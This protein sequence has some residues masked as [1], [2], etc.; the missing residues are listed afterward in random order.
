MPPAYFLNAPTAKVGKNA[1][2][3]LR[4]RDNVYEDDNAYHTFTQDFLFRAVRR[5]VF[6]PAPLPLMRITNNAVGSAVDKMSG[7]GAERKSMRHTQRNQ[8]FPANAW[9][10]A[11]NA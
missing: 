7:S 10:K 2:R 3:N 6:A 4:A 5:I 8:T 9:E 1:G 11:A